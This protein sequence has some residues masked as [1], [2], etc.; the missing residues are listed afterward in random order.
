MAAFSL[1]E[2]SPED[3]SCICGL[4]EPEVEG[5]LLRYDDDD[6]KDIEREM[7]SECDKQM[8]LH[9]REKIF[10]LVKAKVIRCISSKEAARLFG[11]APSDDA[12]E[13]AALLSGHVNLWELTPRRVEHRISHDIMDML[14]FV[15]GTN[16]TFPSKIIKEGSMRKGSIPDTR[17]RISDKELEEQLEQDIEISCG[18]VDVEVISESGGTQ[19]HSV[20]FPIEPTEGGQDESTCA[21]TTGSKQASEK[22]DSSKAHGIET[23]EKVKCTCACHAGKEVDASIGAL[24]TPTTKATTRDMAS[25]TGE[26]LI[27]RTEFDY[28]CEYVEDLCKDNARDVREIQKWRGSTQDRIKKIEYAHKKEIADLKKQQDNMLKAIGD[29]ERRN[30]VRDEQAKGFAIDDKEEDIVDDD[31]VESVW[32]IPMEQSTPP[33]KEVAAKVPKGNGRAGGQPRQAK[34]DKGATRAAGPQSSSAAEKAAYKVGI[35]II[36]EEELSTDSS[37]NTE[38]SAP[39][40][41]RMKYGE[42]GSRAS[43][44]GG[45]RGRG[46]GRGSAKPPQVET[47]HEE[48]PVGRKDRNDAGEAWSDMDDGSYYESLEDECASDGDVDTDNITK[49]AK[50][51]KVTTNKNKPSGGGGKQAK[52][53]VKTAGESTNI[54][55]NDSATDR[56]DDSGS[57]RSTYAQMAG[58]EPWLQPN[59]KRKNVDNKFRSLKGVKAILHREVYVQGLD[60]Q[61]ATDYTEM[62]TLV[63]NYCKKNGVKVVFLKII[64]VKYDK[65]Q[66]GCKLS[67][68]S[69]DFERVLDDS[70]WPED[71]SVRAWRYKKRDGPNPGARDGQGQ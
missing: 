63:H 56:A 41:K 61:G 5:I 44:R 1:A 60:L 25:Q 11:D 9:A 58:E 49:G 54:R 69:E 23:T 6:R 67:V 10:G 2:D 42:D 22:P 34:N 37:S 36:E 53:A 39:D 17:S 15:L 33:M 16:V 65:S 20:S 3:I 52:S 29:L 28:Q 57:D 13:R 12:V 64:P 24:R 50:T 38:G 7:V 62:E 14:T 30:E 71:V 19:V 66:V 8:L 26:E 70:F 4:T 45:R 47:I 18:P 59:R 48:V 21:T 43:R 55:K 27:T 68:L 31:D 40:P 51:D 32:D 35:E 46:R